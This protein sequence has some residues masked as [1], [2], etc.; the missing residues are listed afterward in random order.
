MKKIA[1]SIFLLLIGLSVFAVDPGLYFKAGDDYVPIAPTRVATSGAGVKVA[2]FSVSKDKHKIK[3]ATSDVKTT[4]NPKFVISF[5]EKGKKKPK[6]LTRHFAA[7]MKP[8][9]FS[10]Y[11]L[12]VNKDTRIIP[13]NPR[14]MGLK[15]PDGVGKTLEFEKIDDSTYE[16]ALSNLEPG[17]YAFMFSYITTEK[18]KKAVSVLGGDPVDWTTAFCF[19]VEK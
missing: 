15:A 19:T 3:G 5:C 9:Y 8:E 13:T 16:V 4:K 11:D 12:E 18:G 7:N 10:L 6:N 1:T 14:I 2:V 17:E